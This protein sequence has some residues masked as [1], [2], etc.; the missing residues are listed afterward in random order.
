MRFLDTNV[1]LYAVSTVPDEREKAE[2][3]KAV[4]ASTDLSVSVQVLGEFYVQATRASRPGRMTHEQATR[5]VESFTR[6][7]VQSVTL[8]VVRTALDLRA[9]FGLSYWDAMI[10]GAA[11]ASGCAEVLTEDMQ[12]GQD[13]DGVRVVDPFR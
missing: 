5:L 8:T 9:R 11:Q 10:I 1:L 3:A 4:M 2:R 13:L 7:P 12:H 6:Y